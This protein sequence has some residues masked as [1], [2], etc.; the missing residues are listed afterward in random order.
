MGFG[1]NA[2]ASYC[3]ALDISLSV[4]LGR[5]VPCLGRL[6]GGLLPGSSCWTVSVGEDGDMRF[7]ISIEDLEEEIDVVA[8]LRWARL[9]EEE[10]SCC[11][12]ACGVGAGAGEI[13]LEE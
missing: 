4:W 13:G 9:E 6:R 8:V 2:G 1:E 5:A 7:P 3:N 10:E 11:S 12:K